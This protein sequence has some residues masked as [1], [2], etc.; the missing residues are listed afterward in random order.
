[1]NELTP[2]KLTQTYLKIKAKRTELSS[3]FRE[4]DG[5]LVSQLD[6][7]KD[8]LLKYCE[9]QDVESVRTNSG[10]FY[11]SVKNRYWTSDWSSMYDFILEHNVPEFFDKRLNQGNVKQFLEDNPDL[12]PKGLNC[13]SEYIISVRKK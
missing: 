8:A 9:E 13:D 11:R 4:E 10:L 3:K 2:E 12:L 6:T 5:V 7:I 1:M